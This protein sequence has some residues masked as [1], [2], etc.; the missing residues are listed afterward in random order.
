MVIYT[1]LR[2][3]KK[4]SRRDYETLLKEKS[5]TRFFKEES[6]KSNNICKKS[7]RKPIQS[8][9]YEDIVNRNFSD[10]Y[11]DEIDLCYYL[12]FS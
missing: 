3:N 6:K 4:I 10:G 8:Q 9:L 5:H 11:I 1:N 12:D 2:M 7:K